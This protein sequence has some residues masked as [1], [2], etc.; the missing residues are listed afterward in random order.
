MCRSDG[1]C[2]IPV[3]AEC[4]GAMA[5]A[6]SGLKRDLLERGL[7]AKL[8]ARSVRQNHEEDH[9]ECQANRVREGEERA[10]TQ[11]ECITLVT[12]RS[13]MRE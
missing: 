9:A 2:L 7:P 11:Q 10:R 1:V 3:E 13:K 5:P 4:V 6:L 8:T 12:A